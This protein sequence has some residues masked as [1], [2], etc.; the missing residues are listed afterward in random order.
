M[1]QPGAT[2]PGR[3]SQ[4]LTRNYELG[5]E[6]AVIKNP[7]GTVKRL[8]VAVALRDVKGAKA[9]NTVDIAAI[10]GLVK[11][12]VGF[13]A[14]RGDDVVVS[15]RPFAD[16]TP[17]EKSWMDGIDFMAIG[18]IIAALAAVAF[19]VFGIGRPFLKSRAKAAAERKA[20]LVPMLA[21]E[22]AR[23]RRDMPITLDMIS[24]APSYA[25]R[26]ALV[27]DFV[28]QDPKRAAAVMRSLLTPEKANG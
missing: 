3:T 6:V 27:R 5:R 26:A 14:A 24:A 17:I 22:V 10:D 11:R 4:D 25:D 9:R 19:V 2:V 7:V 15:S 13:D 1:T 8:T 23:Q 28:S 21:D 20:E 18:R 16:A 12:A